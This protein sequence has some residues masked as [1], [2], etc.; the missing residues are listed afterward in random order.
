M[1]FSPSP[2]PGPIHASGVAHPAQVTSAQLD[3]LLQM[4]R[5]DKEAKARALTIA[6]GQ[7]NLQRR[8]ADINNL[9]LLKD[10][11]MDLY[12]PD[13]DEEQRAEVRGVQQ[14]LRLLIMGSTPGPSGSSGSQTND[15]A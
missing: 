13:M 14:Q 2:C 7:A 3:E 12:G 1:H 10:T 15:E 8:Q 4:K 9:K 11:L 5:Q 6:E